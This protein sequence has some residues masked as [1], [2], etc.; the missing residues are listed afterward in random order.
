MS[1][2]KESIHVGR[3][4]ST[5][6]QFFTSGNFLIDTRI[7]ALFAHRHICLEYSKKAIFQQMMTN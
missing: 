3:E 1:Q 7:G 4:G 2:Q 6:A 5:G